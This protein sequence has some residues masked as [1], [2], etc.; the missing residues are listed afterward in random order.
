MAW[1]LENG[2]QMSVFDFRGR[3]NR[4]KAASVLLAGGRLLTIRGVTIESVGSWR[5]PHSAGVYPSGW[6]VRIPSLRVLMR[7]EPT[8][9]DQEMVIPSQLPASYWEGSSRLHGTFK[10]TAVSGLGYTELTGYAGH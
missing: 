10:G 3:T 2:T 9:R 1:Q 5:S 8:V 6:I 7:V 4:V